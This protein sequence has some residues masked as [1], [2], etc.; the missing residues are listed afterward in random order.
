MS[1][2]DVFLS[3]MNHKDTGKV[4][5]DFGSTSVT[6]MHVYCVDGL[7][8][9]YGLEKRPV[10]IYEPYQMLGFIED[11]L[12]EAMGIT[13]KGEFPRTT[14]FGFE[15]K[16]WKD[17]KLDNGLEVLVPG[18]FNVTRD[19]AGNTCLY[20]EGDLSAP[21]SGHLPKGGYYFD[22]I[23]RQL[24]FDEDNPNVEDNLMEFE[25][26]N[27]IDL[28]YQKE[29]LERLRREDIGVVTNFGGTG[30]GD[31]ALVPAVQLK[32]PR[33]IRGIEEWYVTLASR[34][35]FVREL[36]DRQTDIAIENLKTYFN[37]VGNL[38]DVVFI[39]GT[40]FGTQN[41]TFCS[42]ETF[43]DLYMPYYKKMNDWI[44]ANTTW[45]SFKHSCGA[46]ADFIPMFID[47]GF[48]ILN[49]VQCS[50]A[51]MEPEK[52]KR[53]YGNDIVFWGGGVDTQNLL[54]NGSPNEI[55]DQVLLRLEIFSKNGGYVFNAIHNVQGNVPIEN[56]AAMIETVKEF[57]Q[58]V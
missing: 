10:K 30:L 3:A 19:K 6:G 14:M 26:A 57:N 29:E 23:I 48:D 53:E 4:P 24:E 9:Y 46:V 18:N 2:R 47:A 44:H 15:N 25:P 1:K 49:P 31:I 22:A 8:K 27:D 13:V 37:A 50:C 54:P 34:K 41:G 36:F 33:G 28:K 12:A 16:G 39:C 56:I 5:V 51:G 21:A 20:P 58:G 35:D 38:P 55:R 43:L 11:D 45:K 32:Y 40:D 7:R 52:I 17:Y 42:K